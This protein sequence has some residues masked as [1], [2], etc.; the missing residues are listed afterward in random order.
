M[1]TG[2]DGGRRRRR[3]GRRQRRG[4]RPLQR[5]QRDH[6]P[7]HLLL[8]PSPVGWTRHCI[9]PC[10]SPL[11]P[12]GTADPPPPER[13]TTC[14]SSSLPRR[15]L[16]ACA[17][18]LSFASRLLRWLVVASPF[19]T[20][21]PPC[22]ARRTAISRSL[23]AW[24]HRR[25]PFRIAVAPSIV[26]TVAL[27]S[28][29]PSPPSLVDCCRFHRHRRVKVPLLPSQSLC[30]AC[31]R[32]PSPSRH[33]SPPSLVDCCM[34]HVQRHA[35][36]PALLAFTIS[37]DRTTVHHPSSKRPYCPCRCSL[38]TIRTPSRTPSAERSHPRAPI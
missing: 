14:P 10:V 29:R 33:P 12:V 13:R 32:R 5:K 23:D 4:G 20:S 8:L 38:R 31:H 37:T 9:M 26:V 22:V 27:P 18:R 19:V 7:L 17:F 2:T 11:A 36:S 28:R 6:P 3:Q 16:S 35:P 21:P 15:L 30:C 24:L 25:C 1:G 34:F